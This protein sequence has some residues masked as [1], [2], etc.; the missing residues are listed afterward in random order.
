MNR[1]IKN[2]KNANI[3]K[4]NKPFKLK[5]EFSKKIFFGISIMV[6]MVTIF[7]CYMMYETKN[8][9]P[10]SYLIP[11]LFAELGVATG[12]YYDKARKENELKIKM[13]NQMI[14]FVSETVSDTVND[15]KNNGG[16]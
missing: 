9:S 3:N 11:S 12:F 13:S 7:A 16:I 4:N 6:C 2:I 8:L 1:D 14:D 15:I 10:L 5:M